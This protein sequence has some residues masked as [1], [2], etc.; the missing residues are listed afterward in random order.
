MKKDLT[1]NPWRLKTTQKIYENPWIKVQEDQVVRPDGSDGIY[2]K[3]H[4]KN[5]AVGVVPLDENNNTWLVGQFR[6]TLDEYSW[7]IPTGGVPMD[8]DSLAGAQR[9]LREETG[10]LAKDWQRILKLHTSNS[11][12]DEYG[13]I[14][15]ARQLT[16]GPTA[17]EATEVLQI[18]KLPLEEALKMVGNGEITDLM[19]SAGLMAVARKLG[20]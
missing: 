12:T 16:A 3:V 20:F 17:W 1:T 19:S 9:E 8:E 4:F 10:L 15:L 11:V 13:Y 5:K 2:G 7:E 18:R 14:Y 6:Y